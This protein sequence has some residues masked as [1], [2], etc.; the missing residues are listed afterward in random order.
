M[1][2]GFVDRFEE[3]YAVGYRAGY[4]VLGR[5]AE[6]E[7][8][9]QEAM[10]RALARWDRVE[11]H[12][13]AWV[14]RVSTNLAL[15]A[16]GGSV[17]NAGSGR[18]VPST[19]RSPSAATTS[20]TALRA[21]PKRQREAVVLRY[22]VDLSE[23]ET[24]QGDGLCDR[25]R[26]ERRRPR[27]RPPAPVP[28]AG[29]GPG[30]AMNFDDLHDPEPAAA[31][32]GHAGER[33]RP[34]ST[35]PPPA[36]RPRRRRRCARGGARR[37][38]AGVGTDRRR[39]GRPARPGDGAGRARHVD[40]RPAPTT[41]R[42]AD[43][44]ESRHVDDADHRGARAGA[45]RRGDP[46][47]RRRRAHRRRRSRDGPLRRRRPACAAGGGRADDRRQRR[48]DRRRAHVRQHVL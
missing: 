1:D 32:H 5:R 46:C 7:D 36:G 13:A 33:R 6:A 37:R 47:R 29:V 4:A 44:D 41:S 14:A 19:I 35:D 34:R 21:L 31:G 16:C 42:R 38:A 27:T 15:D 22:I 39:G 45:R 40:R 48:R 12:A 3:L 24:A 30:G 11:D 23:H 17:A 8:C 9:A 20:S 28:R 18:R 10:A 2:G 26:E 25:H 43:D